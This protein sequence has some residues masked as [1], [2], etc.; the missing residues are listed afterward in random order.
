MADIRTQLRQLIDEQKID[1]RLK[2]GRVTHPTL[3]LERTFCVVCGKPKGWVST[4]TYEFIR[5]NNV[6]VICEQCDA[7]MGALP[8]PKANIKEIP[9][10]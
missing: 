3:N 1:S 6:V 8:L 10:G 4:A 5:A 7:D 2:T 9:N